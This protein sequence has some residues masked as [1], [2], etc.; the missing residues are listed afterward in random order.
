[1]EFMGSYCNDYYNNLLVV[2]KN[3][4][5]NHFLFVLHRDFW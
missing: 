5:I 1:M 2:K 3:G 4:G